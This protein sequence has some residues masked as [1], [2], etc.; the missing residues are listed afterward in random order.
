MFQWGSPYS[1][2]MTTQSQ[3][4]HTHVLDTLGLEIAAGEHPP[5]QVLR[6]DELAQRFDVSRTVVR[7]VIR[8]LE[9][10]H[11]VESRRRVGVTVRSAEEWNVYDPQVIRWRLA[12]CRPP[13]PTALTDGPA[14]G[15]RARRRLS[16]GPPRHPGPVRAAHRTGPRHGRHLAR[17]AAGGVSR[18]R[19]RVPPD[20]AQR[21]RQRD[22]RA[23]RRRGR[24]GPGGAHPSPGDVRGP[25]PGGRHPP[26]PARRSGARGRRG[27]GGAADEGDRGGRPART[28]R[29]RP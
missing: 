9:S 13:A 10:M 22:V 1:W 25:R 17:P 3:G 15:D 4:L 28:R 16:R 20:R 8:V 7:E 6:T 19:H 11:L 18:T 12:G 2:F 5:G 21:L 29:A 23:P 24:R 27:G 14:L 26:C